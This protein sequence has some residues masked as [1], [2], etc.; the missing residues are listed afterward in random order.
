MRV[1][2]VHHACGFDTDAR[3]PDPLQMLAQ[4]EAKLE[5]PTR[6]ALY[7]MLIFRS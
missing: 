6:I 5:V 2:D 3:D 4:I 7:F 1:V